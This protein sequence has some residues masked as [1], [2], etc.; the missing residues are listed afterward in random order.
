MIKARALYD[1]A[2]YEKA[3]A[4]CEQV[5]SVNPHLIEPRLI[6]MRCLNKLNRTAEAGKERKNIIEELQI[7]STSGGLEATP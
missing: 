4:E 3:L 1:S 7:F 6:K 2:S 5:L